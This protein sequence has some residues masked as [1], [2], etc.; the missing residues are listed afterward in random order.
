MN[1]EITEVEGNIKQDVWRNRRI[2]KQFICGGRE[3]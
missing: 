2:S 1:G 3:V